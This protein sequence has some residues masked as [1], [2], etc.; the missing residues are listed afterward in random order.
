[1]IGFLNF[2]IFQWFFVRL[3]WKIEP[4]IKNYKTAKHP[5]LL[6]YFVL[7]LTGWFGISYFPKNYKTILLLRGIEVFVEE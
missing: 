4:S 3:C 1:M 6:M 7:P 2:F 5:L